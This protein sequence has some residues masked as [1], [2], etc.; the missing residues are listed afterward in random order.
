ML[1]NKAFIDATVQVFAKYGSVQW[2]KKGEYPVE[3]R[4]MTN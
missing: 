2:V 3:R 1:Q 4:L